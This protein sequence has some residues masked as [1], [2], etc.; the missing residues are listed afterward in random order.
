MLTR[1]QAPPLTELYVAAPGQMQS[2]GSQLEPVQKN[3]EE[4]SR[5]RDS[6]QEAARTRSDRRGEEGG[7]ELG[8]SVSPPVPSLGLT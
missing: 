7:A 4:K 8:S 2:L 1:D 3:R 5:A 6:G